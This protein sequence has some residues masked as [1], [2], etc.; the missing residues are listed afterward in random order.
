MFKRRK[1]RSYPQMAQDLVYPRGGWGRA[2]RYIVHRLRRLPDPP[3]RVGRGIAAGVFVSF[4]PLIGAHVGLAVIAA[5]VV[6]GNMLAALLGTLIGNPLTL[7]FVAVA[8]VG[9][10]RAILGE[11]GHI[12]PQTII[13]EIGRAAGEIGNNVLA[14]ASD[15]EAHWE[16]L[17]AVWDSILLPYAI[18]GLVLGLVA[19]LVAHRLTVPLILAYQRRRTERRA[20]RARARAR[21]LAAAPAGSGPDGGDGGRTGKGP[22]GA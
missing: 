9:L 2:G 6:R 21:V 20:E 19:A 22:P 11:P 16:H 10:G 8:C 4:S 15:R 5:W 13:S 1:P 7:P 17:R 18:G 14:M 12:G 3:H